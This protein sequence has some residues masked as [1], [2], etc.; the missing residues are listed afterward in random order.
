L[1]ADGKQLITQDTGKLDEGDNLSSDKVM[2]FLKG[3]APKK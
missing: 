2:A 3:W 1:D